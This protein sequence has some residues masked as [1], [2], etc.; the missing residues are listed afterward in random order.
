MLPA[1][2]KQAQVQDG[3]TTFQFIVEH[4]EY[5]R[6]EIFNITEMAGKW[7]YIQVEADEDPK[8]P[9]LKTTQTEAVKPI[10]FSTPN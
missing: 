7:V 3:K 10:P 4:D 6:D 5:T 1:K 2:F 8:P 9:E